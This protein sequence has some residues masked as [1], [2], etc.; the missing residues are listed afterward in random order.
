MERARPREILGH[1][2]A[3]GGV[4]LF[5]E[6]LLAR[7]TPILELRI[8][9]VHGR[10][11][12]AVLP[13]LLVGVLVY[14]LA[15]VA[16]GFL[17]AR[18]LRFLAERSELQREVP[19]QANAP[20]L[21]GWRLFALVLLLA[22]TCAFLVWVRI[23]AYYLPPLAVWLALGVCGL[24]LTLR[25]E[26]AREGSPGRDRLLS[27]WEWAALGASALFFFIYY[28]H[29]VTSWRYSW[30]GD[31]Y[32][33]KHVADEVLL[34][35]KPVPFD[36]KGVYRFPL[37]GSYFQAM[38]MWVLG[39]S[40]FTWRIS[41]ILPI[42]AAGPFVYL[43]FKL[44]LG[45]QVAL[46]ALCFWTFNPTLG[47]FARIAYNNSQVYLPIFGAASMLLAGHL[48]GRLWLVYVAGWLAGLGFY[49]VFT[50]TLAVP[51][52]LLLPLLFSPQVRKRAAGSLARLLPRFLLGLLISAGPALVQFDIFV[53]Q[54][55]A[56]T[57]EEREL[58][59]IPG[60]ILGSLLH[61]ANFPVQS[62]FLLGSPY[63]SLERLFATLGVGAAIYWSRHPACAFLVATYLAGAIAAGGMTPGPEPRVTRLMLLVP[64]VN[65]FAAL[66]FC[67]LCCA[68][69]PLLRGRL[70]GALAGL[71]VALGI[72]TARYRERFEARYPFTAYSYVVKTGIEQPESDVL[73]VSL[74]QREVQHYLLLQYGMERRF[75]EF[76][77]RSCGWPPFRPPYAVAIA[78]APTAR[79][80]MLFQMEK[81]LD[82]FFEILSCHQYPAVGRVIFCPLLV[83]PAVR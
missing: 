82:A 21:S 80:P 22:A 17:L 7:G 29:D 28:G 36:L 45:R 83:R 9:R 33:F 79:S 42:A 43:L 46:C 18:S 4:A 54:V 61:F 51:F 26:P 72:S 16:V 39:P 67:A 10:I 68:A 14:T 8:A 47:S 35:R 30:I 66:G 1:L 15:G 2:L 52:A 37:L 73:Y 64:W 70:A 78:E 77:P 34:G 81:E 12:G 76:M 48:T 63:L 44:M 32:S 65:A 13:S 24:V 23:G 25:C 31:E 11:V 59:T 74:F 41:S 62:H 19:G 56:M 69:R 75:D 50:A 53:Y 58:G 20:F 5:L 60:K 27:G 49:T 40:N 38:V 6:T 3:A 55:G 57:N 71:V